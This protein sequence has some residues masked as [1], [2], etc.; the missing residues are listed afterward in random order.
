M[1]ITKFHRY[2]IIITALLLL[3]VYIRIQK[4]NNQN[5]FEPTVRLWCDSSL[6]LDKVVDCVNKQYQ[7]SKFSQNCRQQLQRRNAIKQAMSNQPQ[8]TAVSYADVTEFKPLKEDNTIGIINSGP[9]GTLTRTDKYDTLH[10]H[11]PQTGNFR[12]LSYQK[13]S[14]SG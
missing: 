5:I 6:P 11:L 10:L 2:F 4:N 12:F 8:K 13:V 7:S 14:F 9:V 1:R 3:A